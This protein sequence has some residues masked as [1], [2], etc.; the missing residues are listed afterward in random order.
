MFPRRGHV[1]CCMRACSRLD[2]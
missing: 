1:T 2:G